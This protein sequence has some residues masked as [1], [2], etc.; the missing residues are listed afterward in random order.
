MARRISDSDSRLGLR[1][2]LRDLHILF[3]VVELGSMA[4]AASHLG[5]TQPT[6]SEAIADLEHAVGVRLLDRGPHGVVPTIYGDTFLKRG[7]EAFDALKQGMRDVEFL[8]TPGTGEVWVG[9]SEALLAG[10]VPAIIQRL[11]QRCPKVVVHAAEANAS[12][13]DFQKLRERKLDLMIGRIMNSQVDDDLSV[14]I[15]FEEPHH[16]VVAAHNRWASRRKVTLAELINEHWI[17]SEQNNIVQTLVSGVFCANGLEVPP[18]SV[19]S[20]SM[21]LHLQLLASGDYIGT[22]TNSILQYCADRW[23]LKILPLHLGIK[24]PVG[25][26]TLKNRTLSPV[27]Q[28]FVEDARFLAKSLTKE[29]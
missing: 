10:Y 23:S 25:I 24:S 16:V 22:L 17:F 27:V 5:I 29:S 6:I 18:A 8:A 28:L 13:F 14:E 21:S 4:K 3:S 1:I 20:T 11:A 26:F 12:D 7:L 9:A 15:L 19:V 2:K